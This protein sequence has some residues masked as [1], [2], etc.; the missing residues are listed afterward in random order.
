MDA[1]MQQ[2]HLDAGIASTR[3]LQENVFMVVV[4]TLAQI[5]LMIVGPPGSSKTLAVT[6]VAENARGEYSKSAFYKAVPSLIPYHYQCSRRSTSKQIQEVFE[7]AIE[8]QTK[9]GSKGQCFVFMDE[10]GLP[11]EERESLKVLH[12]YLENHLKVAARVSFVAIS[13]HALDAAKSNRCALLTRAKPDHQELRSVAKGCLGSEEELKTLDSAVATVRHGSPAVLHLDPSGGGDGLLDILCETYD[14]CMSERP[15]Q[16]VGIGHKPPADFASFFG[17]RDF[18]HFV[19]LLGRLAHNGEGQGQGHARPT[20]TCEKLVEAL[21]RN[22]NGVENKNLRELMDYFMEPFCSLG[23]PSLQSLRHSPLQLHNPLE[24]MRR[25]LA[26]QVRSAAPISRYILVVDTTTD[27]S[28]LRG[29]QSLLAADAVAAARARAESGQAEGAEGIGEAELGGGCKTLK[30]SNFAEDSDVQQ[31]HVISQVKWAAEK[32]QLVLLSQ[33]GSINE[34]FY[35]LFN[36]HFRKFEE[37]SDRG[38]EVVYQ[39]NIAVGAYSRLCR[40]SQGFQC[41]VHLSLAELQVAPAPFL[42]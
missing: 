31:I 18:M 20:I 26:E 21:Q 34:S 7:R 33:T 38:L 15:R 22:F 28:I 41:I 4:C 42:N 1:L 11:E 39:A 13:N 32:G 14:A 29:L 12:Y 2:T 35:D 3:G 16:G 6:V 25:S 37:N 24:L 23:L 36:Q 30:L 10:A 27:D 5:P 17:L 8:R 40:V 9:E 19:K